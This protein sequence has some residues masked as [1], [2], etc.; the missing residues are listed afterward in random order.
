MQDLWND[1]LSEYVDGELTPSEREHAEEH[2]ATCPGCRETLAQLRVV[3]AR[4]ATL[5]DPPAPDD[6]WAGIERRIGPAGSTSAIGRV[7]ALPRRR[8]FALLPALAAAAAVLVVAGVAFQLARPGSRADGRD[9]GLLAGAAPETAQA[10]SFD[11]ARVD[12]EIAD[13]QQALDRGRGKL[14][15]KTV[16]VLE[17][18]L[19]VIR[20]AAAD[21]RA[22]LAA[23]PANR[24]LQRYFAATVNS[25][26]QLMRRATAMVGV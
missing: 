26:L 2:L 14:D 22:A 25:K 11:A 13:L 18:D 1:R 7:L 23:D 15:P 16:K 3:K 10:A 24:D 4:A 17:A 21:A 9:G 12:G 8:A 19:A 6:L 5:V 20:K